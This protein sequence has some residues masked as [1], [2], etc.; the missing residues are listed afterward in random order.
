MH[1]ISHKQIRKF[2]QKHPDSSIKLGRWYKWMKRGKYKNLNDLRRK[3][4]GVDYIGND[5]YVFNIAGNKYRLVAMINFKAQRAYIKYIGT[6]A[7]YNKID[8]KNI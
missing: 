3:Y 8:C 6:H 7:N 5:R 2:I 4:S 1:V